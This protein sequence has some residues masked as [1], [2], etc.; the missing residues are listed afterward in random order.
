MSIDFPGVARACGY[1]EARWSSPVQTQQVHRVPGPLLTGH[2]GLC[3]TKA[4]GKGAKREKERF[5]F[6]KKKKKNSTNGSVQIEGIRFGL[7][8]SQRE[9][10]LFLWS[11]PKGAQ[12]PC[13][14][15]GARPCEHG[16][17]TK[18]EKP[19]GSSR[20]VRRLPGGRVPAARDGWLVFW[21][22]PPVWVQLLPVGSPS[23]TN[24]KG[25]PF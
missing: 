13:A 18:C 6:K 2:V 5:F 11:I 9:P 16:G 8:E 4:Q 3:C 24:Q 12:T 20:R 7:N 15:P 1:K 22:T 17:P 19:Y 21:R 14:S 10:F 23:S 25:S